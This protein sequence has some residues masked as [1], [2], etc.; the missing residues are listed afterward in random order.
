MAPLGTFEFT[1]TDETANSRT[2]ALWSKICSSAN[3][4]SFWRK[5]NFMARS[6]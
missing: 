6:C 1:D 4:R 5:M 3:L 2:P